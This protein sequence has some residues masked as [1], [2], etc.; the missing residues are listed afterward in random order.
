MLLYY[1]TD[2]RSFL[3][4]PAAQRDAL[5]SCIA[6][7]ARA[8]VD[9]IQLREKDLDLDELELLAREA[10]HVVRE[11]SD[12]TKLLVNTH[13]EIALAVGADGVHLPANA[14]PASKIRGDWL[15]Q[16][17]RPPII[18]VSAHFLDDVRTA[19]RQDASFTVFA[20]VFEKV[21]A[22]LTGV[23][24]EALREAC[25]A[26]EIPVLALGGVNVSNAAAC[27]GAGAAGL[28]GIRL[29]QQHDV[30]ATVRSLRALG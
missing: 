30:A 20:P 26:T 3:G 7:S 12:T 4:G 9:Y 6:E 25:A 5:V 17:D 23:G 24:L 13:A 29:F 22:N 18:G 15:R 19:Q 21:A 11:N 10:L 14:P 27:L 8:G 2:R 16:C 28:A 1:I